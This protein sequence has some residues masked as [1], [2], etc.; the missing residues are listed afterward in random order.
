MNGMEVLLMDREGSNPTLKGRLYRVAL[1]LVIHEDVDVD[2]LLSG[3]VWAV[4]LKKNL[5]EFHKRK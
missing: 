1:R 4:L 5:Q 3:R 2:S